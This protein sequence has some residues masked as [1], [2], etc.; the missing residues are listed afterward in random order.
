M[1]SNCQWFDSAWGEF[2]CVVRVVRV[3]GGRLVGDA[4]DHFAGLVWTWLRWSRRR[5]GRSMLFCVGRLALIFIGMS[6]CTVSP[7]F[8][9]G[10]S[11]PA[12]YS[13]SQFDQ[14]YLR[15]CSSAPLATGFLLLLLLPLLT[16]LTDTHGLWYFGV[17]TS[18]ECFITSSHF[19]R[20]AN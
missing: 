13:V 2:F 18:E 7:V 4:G 12:Q 9:N 1:S 14:H 10:V 17:Q 8:L 5:R 11:V 3:G 19:G 15:Y 6:S 16:R 20:I